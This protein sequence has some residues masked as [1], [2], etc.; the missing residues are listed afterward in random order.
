MDFSSAALRR[1]AQYYAALFDIM[2]PDRLMNH[3]FPR[4]CIKHKDLDGGRRALQI[5]CGGPAHTALDVHA[6]D[7]D[8][9]RIEW[10]ADR[11]ANELVLCLSVVVAC[12]AR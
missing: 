4:F 8:V 10:L 12:G 7:R 6:W 9:D 1:M 11:C 2:P 5:S 3:A